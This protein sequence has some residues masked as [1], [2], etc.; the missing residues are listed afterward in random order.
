MLVTEV[1]GAVN[2]GSWIEVEDVEEGDT[3]VIASELCVCESAG[4]GVVTLDAF[5][6][7]EVAKVVGCSDEVFGGADFIFC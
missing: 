4:I 6:A 3:G 5:A 1:G 2:A 7:V